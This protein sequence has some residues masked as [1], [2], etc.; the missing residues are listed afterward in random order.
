MQ[1]RTAEGA[2]I[3]GVEIVDGWASREGGVYLAVFHD[4]GSVEKTLW[5][6]WDNAAGWPAL[7]AELV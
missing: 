2:A 7:A 1:Y 3:E 6:V 5:R 4:G